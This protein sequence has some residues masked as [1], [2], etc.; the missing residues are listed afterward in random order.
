[1]HGLGIPKN[2]SAA[3]GYGISKNRTDAILRMNMLNRMKSDK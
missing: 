3:D 2:G 1:M